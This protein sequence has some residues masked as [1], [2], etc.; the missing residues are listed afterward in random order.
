VVPLTVSCK[1]RGH[2]LMKSL[3]ITFR[4]CLICKFLSA[5]QYENNS[6]CTVLGCYVAYRGNF[7]IDVSGQPI[8]PISKGQEFLTLK[9]CS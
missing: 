9:E 7:L 5:G 3:H 4:L 1:D 8:G 6:F 2:Q